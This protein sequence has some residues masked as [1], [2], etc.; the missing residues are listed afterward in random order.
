MKKGTEEEQ[1]RR[2]EKR[3]IKTSREKT[4][5]QKKKD[6]RKRRRLRVKK[7]RRK[8]QRSNKNSNG[9]SS[10]SSSSL[11]LSKIPFS[12]PVCYLSLVSSFTSPSYVI[13]F[14]FSIIKL[15]IKGWTALASL[16]CL[17][18]ANRAGNH[19]EPPKTRLHFRGT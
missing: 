15:V 19:Q 12:N 4:K 8:I 5:D 11:S 18:S 2:R 9:H 13:F 16:C 1:G 10:S 7:E 17:L 14:S 6:Q 3:T